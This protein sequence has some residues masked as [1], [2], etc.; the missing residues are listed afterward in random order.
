MFDD[1]KQF[2]RA[3]EEYK[4]CF[5]SQENLEHL[6]LNKHTSKKYDIFHEHT[7]TLNNIMNGLKCLSIKTNHHIEKNIFEKEREP[8]L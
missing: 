4:Q 6:E 5:N 3:F 8:D 1:I 7:K 2:E